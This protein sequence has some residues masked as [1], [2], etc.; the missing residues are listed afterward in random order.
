ME[1]SRCLTLTSSLRE[2]AHGLWARPDWLAA[3]ISQT[4]QVQTSCPGLWT[5]T[6]KR[7]DG[8]E[9]HLSPRCHP[10]VLH[11]RVSKETP[12][13]FCLLIS[14]Q[15]FPVSASYLNKWI[16]CRGRR[17]LKGILLSKEQHMGMLLPGFRM[18]VLQCARGRHATGDMRPVTCDAIRISKAWMQWKAAGIFAFLQLMALNKMNIPA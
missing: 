1:K 18:I 16:N 10:S 14:V 7:R 5:M 9:I 15:S 8:Q 6:G 12:S 3:G 4:S 13:G 2:G 11:P 17:R